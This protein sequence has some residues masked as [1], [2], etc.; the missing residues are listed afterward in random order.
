MKNNNPI[1]E[2]LFESMKKD[3]VV[4]QQIMGGS[5]NHFFHFYFAHYVQF[6]TANFQRDLIG[7][8]EN[9]PDENLFVVAI[10]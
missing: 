4:R 3:R 8:L 2:E 5:F 1:T 7:K 10:S 6:P 9:E